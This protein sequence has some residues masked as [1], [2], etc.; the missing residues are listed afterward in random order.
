MKRKFI[1]YKKAIGKC[2]INIKDTNSMQI[3]ECGNIAYG[4]ILGMPV[5]DNHWEPAIA[6]LW[7]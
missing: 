1:R 7:A 6:R 5:C 2:E 4:K 3:K